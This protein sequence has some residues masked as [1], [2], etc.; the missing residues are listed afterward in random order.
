MNIKELCK[1]AAERG[2]SD[3]HLVVGV[4]PVLR[5]DAGA[6]LGRKSGGQGFHFPL[7]FPGPGGADCI[8]GTR[9]RR[10]G[11]LRPHRQTHI[12]RR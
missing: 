11:I 1:I 10:G 7:H 2:A 3:L 9:C 5:I 6:N 4:P 8:R 12:D